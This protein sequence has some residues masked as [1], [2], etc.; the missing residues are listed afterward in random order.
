[1]AFDG[2]LLEDRFR[3]AGDEAAVEEVVERG[4]LSGLAGGLGADLDAVDGI[5][6]A[7]AG[8]REESRAAIGIDEVLGAGFMRE[9]D[10][11]ADELLED[12]RIVLEELA[13]EE[14][15]LHCTDLLGDDLA[16]IGDDAFLAIA[17]EQGG[18]AFEASGVGLDVLAGAGEGGVDRVRRDGALRYVDDAAGGASGEEADREV[19][20]ARGHEMRRNLGAVAVLLRRRVAGVDLGLDAAEALEG[21]RDLLLL[22]LQLLRVGEVLILAA[23]TFTEEVAARLDA[24]GRG[25][26]DADEVAAR[27]VG[28]V[29]P[30]AGH[31]LLAGEGAGDEDDPAVDAGHAFAEVRQAGDLDLDLLMVGE[32]ALPELGGVGFAGLR[33]LEF[34]HGDKVRL[35][36]ER[37][38]LI[39]AEG[40]SL[41]FGV[42]WYSLRPCPTRSSRADRTPACRHWPACGTVPSAKPAACSSPKASGNSPGPSSARSRCSKSISARR[43]SVAPRPPNS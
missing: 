20:A 1:M 41:P 40:L 43:C 2:D 17:E 7:G 9:L 10:G 14:L 8:K 29:V 42:P 5:E 28:G 21:L 11:V 31:D 4:V 22:P 35:P 13:S 3:G 12:G 25:D 32:L 6:E 37:S 19:R 38:R 34:G 18:A 36:A 33:R 16:G 26:D 23:A 39:P 15:Q 27:E 30:D 24:V